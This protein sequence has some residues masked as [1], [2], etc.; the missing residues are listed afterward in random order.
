MWE[1]NYYCISSPH[2]WLKKLGSL[3]DP[4]TSKPKQMGSRSDKFSRRSRQL[5]L[6][7]RVLIGSR[8]KFLAKLWCCVG[9]KCNKVIFVLSAG[10]IMRIGHRKEI[11]KLTFRALALRWSESIGSIDCVCPL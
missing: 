4:I 7:T 5:T 11:G 9:G 3:F 8:G 1:S 10:L 6:F 2:D